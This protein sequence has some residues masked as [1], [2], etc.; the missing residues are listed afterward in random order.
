MELSIRH[1]NGKLDPSL[2]DHVERR[3]NAALDRFERRISR[4][5]VQLRDVNGPRGGIDQEC[6]IAVKLVGVGDVFIEQRDESLHAAVAT[7]V[8]RTAEAVRR[9]VARRKRGVGAG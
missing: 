7:A 8:D 9:A 1:H 2:H 6:R 4:V 3:L 5:N